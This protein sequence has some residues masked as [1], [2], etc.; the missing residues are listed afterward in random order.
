MI[1]LI[2]KAKKKGGEQ[3][4]GEESQFAGSVY[5]SVCPAMSGLQRDMGQEWP[6]QGAVK[7]G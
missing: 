4:S 5:T 7:P 1:E 6:V 2:H 3:V